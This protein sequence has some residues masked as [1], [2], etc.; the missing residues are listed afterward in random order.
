[1]TRDWVKYNI[2]RVF[3]FGDRVSVPPPENSRLAV[4]TNDAERDYFDGRIKSR[5]IQKFIVLSRGDQR[6]L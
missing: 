1:M 3:D 4:Q 5:V 6:P 2:Q